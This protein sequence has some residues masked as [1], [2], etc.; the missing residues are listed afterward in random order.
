MSMEMKV[1]VT[2]MMKSTLRVNRGQE[3]QELLQG[4]D[5]SCILIIIIILVIKRNQL[6]LG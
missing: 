1:G 2:N 3:K 6:L 4:D 5:Q